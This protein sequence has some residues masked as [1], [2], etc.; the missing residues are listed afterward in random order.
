MKKNQLDK[1]AKEYINTQDSLPDWYWKNGLHDAL[2]KSVNEIQRPDKR[3]R[4]G[5][6][7]L[8]EIKLDCSGAM[9]ERDIKEIDF[10]NYSV[11]S[12]NYKSLFNVSSDCWWL[13]DAPS[14]LADGR[15][16]LRLVVTKTDDERI[17]FDI[18]F[19]KIKTIR[20]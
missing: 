14:A 11:T 13:E 7:N 10:Y 8:L 12:G 9:F 3:L 1:L 19:D 15:Y 16:S 17:I 2:I 18:E 6:R 4:A 20:G 5:D